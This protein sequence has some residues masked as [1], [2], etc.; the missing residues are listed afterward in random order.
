MLLAASIVKL[1]P[2]VGVLLSKSRHFQ[3]HGG[4]LLEK[5]VQLLL[6]TVATV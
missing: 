1:P 4:Q 6:N 3:P 2:E 5:H